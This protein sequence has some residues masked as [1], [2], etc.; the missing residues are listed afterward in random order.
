MCVIVQPATKSSSVAVALVSMRCGWKPQRPSSLDRAIEKHP[1]NEAEISSSGLVP[2]PS[3][4]RVRKEYCVLE[5]T[6]LSVVKVT[7]S[8]CSF[9][10][11]MAKAFQ[12]KNDKAK[13]YAF[14]DCPANILL[15]A[16]HTF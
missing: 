10:F 5:L 6:P 13:C 16:R 1:P 9:A 14:A 15:V 4:N 12:F 7:S 11:H 2:R 3:A 8:S